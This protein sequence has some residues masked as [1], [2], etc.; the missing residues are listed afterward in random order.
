MAV[1][2]TTAAE[3]G[4]SRL[5]RWV[6]EWCASTA[7]E[8]RK[9]PLLFPVRQCTSS[10]LLQGR[11][12]DVV[13]MAAESSG[14]AGEVIRRAPWH[15]C[16]MLATD[17]HH[18]GSTHRFPW[19][20]NGSSGFLRNGVDGDDD[21]SVVGSRT[22]LTELNDKK[23]LKETGDT[24][25]NRS[26]LHISVKVDAMVGTDDVMN[27][28]LTRDSDLVPDRDRV[29][30]PNYVDDSLS[31][32]QTKMFEFTTSVPTR[33]RDSIAF[34]ANHAP[35]VAVV[36][37]TDDYR[38]MPS[39]SNA[40]RLTDGL[41][42]KFFQRATPRESISTDQGGSNGYHWSQHHHLRD[43]K[44]QSRDFS[45]QTIEHASTQTPIVF[46]VHAVLDGIR[47]SG[48]GEGAFVVISGYDR[49]KSESLMTSA[50]E[51]VETDVHSTQFLTSCDRTIQ[52]EP[53]SGQTSD[54]RSRDFCTQTFGLAAVEVSSDETDDRS[55]TSEEL[56]DGSEPDKRVD[57]GVSGLHGTSSKR[58]I[59]HGRR[60]P[61]QFQRSFRESAG[62]VLAPRANVKKHKMKLNVVKLC[63]KQKEVSSTAVAIVDNV[64]VK[65]CRCNIVDKP[66][67]CNICRRPFGDSS[68]A[69]LKSDLHDV[70][71]QQRLH[72]TADDLGSMATTLKR[73]SLEG[74][75]V[76]VAEMD[77]GK[78]RNGIQSVEAAGKAGKHH[79]VK[80]G[81]AAETTQL[82]TVVLRDI[83]QLGDLISA[84]QQ[85]HERHG[86][87]YGRGGRDGRHRAPQ[88]ERHSRSAL[89][90]PELERPLSEDRRKTTEFETLR[91]V[92]GTEEDRCSRD[93]TRHPVRS[94]TVVWNS[95]RPTFARY[96]HQRTPQF[97][98]RFDQI[99]TQRENASL[100]YH[101]NRQ[102]FP[103]SQH[104]NTME[105]H[106]IAPHPASAWTSHPQTLSTIAQH[107]PR[108]PWQPLYGDTVIGVTKPTTYFVPG[109][110]SR[111]AFR[112][113]TQTLS[114]NLSNT[115]S[116]RA[117]LS[118]NPARLVYFVPQAIASDCNW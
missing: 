104:I 42:P 64:K 106:R 112:P 108:L 1:T 118:G 76:G 2:R 8:H 50:I 80:H 113:T 78:L 84:K 3:L 52:T 31:C 117:M 32:R 29:D 26:S 65:L 72:E 4:D 110:P 15:S 60:K 98:H 51:M 45:Q 54:V 34:Q 63:G 109:S 89:D 83:R 49:T 28:S 16:E 44:T 7:S 94:S 11:A 40:E 35:D 75:H 36:M 58:D 55:V 96:G 91:D 97:N 23:Q 86:R 20:P 48:S 21:E 66:D 33:R 87:G 5:S 74:R 92:R 81:A 9:A 71:H 103:V 10:T 38:K 13:Q 43:W 105:S 37:T 61:S 22:Q 116:Q 6:D 12:D 19:Q 114:G 59:D 67:Y 41:S 24:R 68:L 99:C 39:P 107:G 95:T 102:A 82:M 70:V 111:S 47:E 79:H 27:S 101:R 56:G 46:R 115:G 69:A 85:L 88:S 14:L 18:D 77:S 17:D 93:V 57:H 73:G 62:V 25:D 53:T 100:D 30:V 90:W